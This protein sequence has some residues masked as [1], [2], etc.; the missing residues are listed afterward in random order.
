MGLTMAALGEAHL[1]LAKSVWGSGWVRKPTSRSRLRAV[2]NLGHLFV[3]IPLVLYLMW[4]LGF[5]NLLPVVH[6]IG[7]NMDWIVARVLVIAADWFRRAKDVLAQAGAPSGLVEVQEGLAQLYRLLDYPEQAEAHNREILEMEVVPAEGYR[8]ARARL[9]IAH[10]L[11]LQGKAGE[12]S[13]TLTELLPVFRRFEHLQRIAQTQTLLGEAAL[14][15]DRPDEAVRYHLDSLAS[16]QELNERA[17]VPKTRDLSAVTDIVHDLEAIQGRCELST[18]SQEAVEAASQQ[19]TERHYRV[20]YL[21][22]TL[23]TFAQASLVILVLLFFFTMRL[24]LRS[25]AGTEVDATASLVKPIQRVVPTHEEMSPDLSLTLDE[26]LSPSPPV[27]LVAGIAVASF[28]GYLLLYT[29]IGWLV[30]VTTP[31]GAIKPGQVQA[32]V[33]DP[34]GIQLLTPA[35]GGQ[36]LGWAQINL[37]LHSDRIVVRRPLQAMSFLALFEEDVPLRV[38]ALTRHY[39]ALQHSVRRRVEPPREPEVQVYNLGFDLLRSKSGWLFLA[40]LVY[41]LGF[42][43][44][45]LLW[46]HLVTQ[47]IGSLPYNAVDFFWLA[48]LGLAFPLAWWFV[49]QPLRAHWLVEVRTPAVWLVGGAGLALGLLSLVQVNLWHLPLGR[50]D[51]ATA[52][53]AILLV[54]LSGRH[55]LR[56]RCRGDEGT[57]KQFA[58]SSP[59]RIAAAVVA[60][61][62]VAAMLLVIGRELVGFHYLALGNSHLRQAEELRMEKDQVA[63]AEK[64]Y[65]RALDAYER[66]LDLRPEA[67][68]H[69]SRGAVLT[70]LKRYEDALT[71]Y[72]LA[73]SKNP[74]EPTYVIN[75]ALVYESQAS[76]PDLKPEQ[77]ATGYG[78]AIEKLTSA[79]D[80]MERQPGR[81]KPQLITAHLLRGAAYYDLGQIHLKQRDQAR[82]ADQQAADEWDAQAIEDFKNAAADYQWLVEHAPDLASGYTGHGWATFRL[83]ATA[84]DD[85]ERREYLDSAVEDFEKALDRDGKEISAKIGLGWAHYFYSQTYPACKREQE[86]PDPEEASE[87]QRHLEAAIAAYTRVIVQEQAAIHYRVRAQLEFLLAHCDEM[88]AWKQYEKSRDN[89]NQAIALDGS[90][91]SWFNTRGNLHY[92]LAGN[93]TD[94]VKAE[95]ARKR[96]IADYRKAT[97]LEPEEMDW[98]DDLAWVGYQWRNRDD[99]YWENAVT[100]FKGIVALGPSPAEDDAYGRLGW[101]AYRY[102]RD[103]EQSLAYSARAVAINPSLANVHFNEGLVHVASGHIGAAVQSYLNG[104]QAAD[105]GGVATKVRDNYYRYAIDDLNAIQKDPEGVAGTFAQILEAARQGQ[106]CVPTDAAARGLLVLSQPGSQYWPLSILLFEGESLLPAARSPD[107]D[108]LYG[109]AKEGGEAGKTVFGWVNS[110]P[111]LLSCPFDVSSLP[112]IEPS[113]IPTPETPPLH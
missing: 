65:E 68:V 95:T 37:L 14:L 2:Y 102:Q 101:I 3:R 110:D 96:A 39:Q 103:Y 82:A 57:G 4:R 89:Y 19:V 53:L 63:E 10:C 105:R 92:N 78:E 44:V 43:V 51:I 69:N 41:V 38:D 45:A 60:V 111:S 36:R 100:G 15:L 13:E 97:E 54:G 113:D 71:A 59:V 22:P 91:A 50:P 8:A 99:Y 90:R 55:I 64:M 23:K 31:I 1:G 62:T 52:L 42:F 35:G 40:S 27:E 107:G 112:V 34:E 58:Y 93:Y 67:Y 94:T 77:R 70:R 81:Y 24:A 56:A 21:H 87:N 17:A 29:V 16:W 28:A 84:G 5:R 75:E 85:E 12:S 25:E 80:R 49:V 7:G 9:G 76:G 6:R 73:Q 61:V 32:V 86:G 33:T 79:I 30:I 11:L 106:V 26:Q 66:S 104:I 98:W 72:R 109:I 46:P 74:R 83:R 88:K 20:R 48:Y 47:S 108:W 18:E